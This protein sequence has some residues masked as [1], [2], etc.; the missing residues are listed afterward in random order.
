M[1][2]ARNPTTADELRLEIERLAGLQLAALKASVFGG[3]TPPEALDYAARLVRL[4]QL[5]KEVGTLK[6]E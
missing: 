5:G 6:E 4:V 2:T 3:M 1:T